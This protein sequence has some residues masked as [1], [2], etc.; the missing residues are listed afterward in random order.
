MLYH[1]HI[2]RCLTSDKQENIKI[3][4]NTDVTAVLLLK[5]SIIFG[6]D[7]LQYCKHVL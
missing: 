7:A 2:K 3:S 1:I 5:S 6:I 4:A